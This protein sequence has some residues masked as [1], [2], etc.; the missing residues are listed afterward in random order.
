MKCIFGC[1]RF[2]VLHVEMESSMHLSESR[3]GKWENRCFY[4]LY[5]WMC[6]SCLD[7][8]VRLR[9]DPRAFREGFGVE[10]F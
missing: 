2:D 8:C 7:L 5:F 9:I 10:A 1:G 4:T 3:S 6:F